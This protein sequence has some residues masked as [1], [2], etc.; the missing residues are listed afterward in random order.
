[1]LRAYLMPSD[2][3][4]EFNLSTVQ[5]Q[6]T[7]MSSFTYI[8]LTL[9]KGY[10]RTRI[11]DPNKN[12]E[13]VIWSFSTWFP[14]FLP[15]NYLASFCIVITWGSFTMVMTVSYKIRPAKISTRKDTTCWWAAWSNNNKKQGL[16][17]SLVTHFKDSIILYV[18]LCA[19]VDV[20]T[21]HKCS[22]HRHQKRAWD[23]WN[24]A[25]R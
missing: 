12:T 1:M 15:E 13:P 24:W 18:C 16:N 2:T 4:L 23:P 6:A 17:W 9:Y 25:C 3:V 8:P 21:A 11:L 10:R 7:D 5:N 14:P 22:T 20:C 19:W